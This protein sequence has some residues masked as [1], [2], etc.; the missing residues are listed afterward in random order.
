MKHWAHAWRA[1]RHAGYRFYFAGQ[2]VSTLGNWIQQVAFGWLA[3]RLTGSAMLLGAVVFL[4]Q[5]PQLFVSPLAGILIDRS[6]IRRLMIVVQF[7]MLLQAASLAGLIWLG[8]I[9]PWHILFAASVFGILNSFDVPLRHAYTSQLVLDRQDLPNAI[10][11]NSLFFNLARFIGPPLAG[12]ILTQTSEASCFAL[13]AISF[14]AT[15]AVLLHLRTTSQTHST[16]A[17]SDVFREGLAFVRKSFPVRH[18]LWQVALLNFLA[19]SYIPLMPAFARDVFHGGPDTLGLLLGSAGAG[20]LLASLM[21]ASRRSVRGLSGVIVQGNFLASFSL[22][23][24]ALS[25]DIG[26]AIPMLFLLGFALISC[27]ASSNT[28]LQTLV[29]ERLR[30][31]VLALYS[32]ANLGAAALGGLFCGAIADS[33]GTSESLLVMGLLMVAAALFF[34]NRLELFRMYLRPVYA[35][36]GIK[37][38]S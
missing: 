18:I 35:R 20:A 32:A 10:A 25:S 26:L 27:N 6:N 22:V 9:V 12:L 24:F 36:L 13:N 33:L 37:H 14:V 21:L 30:G 29:P 15:I 8:W 19:A 7:A 3:Y 23:A 16:A 2:A 1:M 34:F 11:L 28:I 4:T 31:R 17:F 5:I 38:P